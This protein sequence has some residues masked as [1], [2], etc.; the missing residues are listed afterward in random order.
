MNY[1]KTKRRRWFRHFISMPFIYI[2]IFP[3][4]ILD[5]FLEIYHRVCFPLY[6]LPYVS[7]K[8]FIVIDRYKLKYLSFI[9]KINC[10]YCGYANGLLH[11]A[12]KI[13]SETEAYWCGI[14]HKKDSDFVEPK[15]HEDF[16]E[17]GDE[18]SFVKRYVK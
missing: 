4:I 18:K 17:Y 11:Y 16:V 15:H 10:A 13:A 7:R 12:S 14:K 8:K 3:L 2:M 9:E 1:K 6:G 5:V